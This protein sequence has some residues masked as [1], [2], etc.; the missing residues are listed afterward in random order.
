M[1]HEKRGLAII[2]NHMLFDAQTGHSTRNGTEVDVKK[3]EETCKKL[4]FDVI[5]HNDLRRAEILSTLKE[6]E[7]FR[8]VCDG[9]YD[10]RI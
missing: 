1:S 4:E 5:I 2:F 9:L 10:M 7:Y 6:S 3:L 8:G